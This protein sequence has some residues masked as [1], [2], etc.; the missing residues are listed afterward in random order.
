MKTK[1]T[2]LKYVFVM[3]LGLLLNVGCSSDDS[4]DLPELPELPEDGDF[5][6]GDGISEDE[7]E[8]FMG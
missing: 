8:T 2:F 3:G 1:Q 4:V 6:E 7:L 5:I